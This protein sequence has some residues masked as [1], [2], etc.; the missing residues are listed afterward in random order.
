M[1]QQRGFTLIEL[2]VVIAILG[3]LAAVALPRFI[4]A[5]GDAHQAALRGTAAGLASAVSLVRAQYEINRS[6][7]SCAGN[8]QIDVSGFGSGK[9]DVNA[10]G[11]P[12][13]IDLAGSPADSAAVSASACLDLFRQL[14]QASAPSVGLLAGAPDYRASASGSRCTF[15]YQPHDGDDQIVYDASTGEVTYTFN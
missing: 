2:V 11:W 4:N 15:T 3:I 7:G 10:S 14:L 1:R 13:G 8:C 9:V 5:M 12:L 6:N